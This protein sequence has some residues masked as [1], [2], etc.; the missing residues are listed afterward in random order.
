VPR[1]LVSFVDGVCTLED[2]DLQVT[3]YRILPG[4]GAPLR[5]FLKHPR[6]AGARAEDLPP[7][8]ESLAD[9]Y[10][11]PIPVVPGRPSLLTIKEA[12]PARRTIRLLDE[13]E[14]ARLELYLRGSTLPGETS[15]KLRQVIALRHRL[16]AEEQRAE[17]LRSRLE[18]ASNQNAEVRQSVVA[19]AKSAD[20]TLKKRL[21]GRLKVTLEQTDRLARELGEVTV[22]RT[23]LR[24]QL[25]ELMRGLRISDR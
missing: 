7:G 13:G 18:D 1:R 23:E 24:S 4:R 3:R 25:R 19:L 11:I 6:R 8:T 15:G 5:V 9:A 14:A 17:D 20:A 10:I 21:L 16:A 22:R 12:R 2:Q